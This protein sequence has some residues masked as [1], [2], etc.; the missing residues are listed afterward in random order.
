MI[1]NLTP[2]LMLS[3]SKLSSP[4]RLLVLLPHILAS[5]FKKKCPDTLSFGSNGKFKLCIH[6]L[7]RSPHPSPT[8]SLPY[9]HE[10]PKP[11]LFHFS[12]KPFSDPFAPYSSQKASLCEFKLFQNP[13]CLWA[14]MNSQYPKQI[15]G[16]GF[17][18][19]LGGDCRWIQRFLFY[20]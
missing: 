8:L 4:T 14:I 16:R 6:Q 18:S 10:T 5:L 20:G 2:L 11:V 3:C 7:A 13:L 12:L 9:Y 19:S 17:I 1:K 15:L